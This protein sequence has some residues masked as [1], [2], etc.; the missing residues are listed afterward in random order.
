M[1]RPALGAPVG[2]EPTTFERRR[3]HSKFRRQT[4]STIQIPTFDEFVDFKQEGPPDHVT[5][6]CVRRLSSGQRLKGVAVL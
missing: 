4:V 1:G 2:I 6:A 3:K 5:P